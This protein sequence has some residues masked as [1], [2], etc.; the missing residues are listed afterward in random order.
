VLREVNENIS[1]LTAPATE[2]GYCLFVCE[3]SSPSCAEA[4]EITA[5]EYEAVRSDGGCLL[6]APGHQRDGVDR[7]VAG[8]ARFLVVETA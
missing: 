6:V 8:N 7:V 2:V 4:L 1:R 3:C 5:A